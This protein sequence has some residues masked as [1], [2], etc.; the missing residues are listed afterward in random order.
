[1]SK[2]L[3]PVKGTKDLLPVEYN[4]HNYIINVALKLGEIYGFRPLVPPIIEYV[5]IFDRTLGSSSDI[6]SKEM[7]VF[8]DKGGRN[9]CLRPEF[10]ASIMRAVITHGLQTYLP[11]RYFSFGPV[12]RYDN[13]QAG[14]QRQFHQINFE[15]IGS[16][17][18]F[19]D[20]E[21]IKL[22]SSIL[23][24]LDLEE[25]VTLEIN[26]LG[27]E[28]SRE[29][30]QV[31]LIEYF[32]RYRKELSLDSQ[33]RLIKNPLRI[34]DSKD[35][36]DQKICSSAP[37]ISDYYTLQSA[38]HFNKLL[39]Y[40]ELLEIKYAINTR[41]V[42][43]LDYYCHTT[44]EYTTKLLGAQSAILAG[45]RY[46]GLFKQMGGN[47]HLPS[48]GFAGG[49]ERLALLLNYTPTFTRPVVIIPIGKEENNK[50]AIILL[51]ELRSNG[52][53]TIIDLYGKPSERL[54]NANM[55]KASRVIFVGEKEVKSQ[56]YT[57]KDLDNKEEYS[58]IKNKLVDHLLSLKSL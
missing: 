34:L 23:T 19:T 17:N 33:H 40:L 24:K 18:P 45:G 21:M 50:H 30:Y 7:Y 32:S 5:E 31:A 26:S 11:L 16:D 13:P 8:T 36:Y 9:V 46:N 41:L 44:F 51:Q 27:C 38:N 37:K 35:P 48:F 58:I 54:R 42:R 22:A 20:V 2:K 1:M 55:V 28:Q 14:R 6:V 47:Q 4:V 29:R 12:F 25:K 53:A 39:E 43:G 10:T 57:I 56:N 3:Q 49:I 52:I 15:Y